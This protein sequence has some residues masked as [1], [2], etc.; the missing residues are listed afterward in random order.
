MKITSKGMR[1]TDAEY[2]LDVLIYATGFD[3]VDGNY[4]RID[5]RG[6]GGVT[7]QRKWSD[8]ARGYLGM[9]ETDFPNFFM[10]LGPNGPFT[11]LPPSI[12][13]QV[14]WIADTIQHMEGHGIATVEPSPNAEDEWMQTCRDISE[15]TLFAKADSWIFG[16]N[17]PGKKRSVV[18]YM[19]GLGNY[20]QAINAVKE[21]G[22]ASMIFDPARAA[23]Q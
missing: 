12:E 6:R 10:V 17:I 13:T 23:A 3:A 8:G 19:G 14:D 7:M 9:M 5:L 20:T 22:Y 15:M 18:F 16:A 4:T 2:E 21:S 11:N 1:T